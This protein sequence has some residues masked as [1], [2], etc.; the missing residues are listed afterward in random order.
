MRSSSNSVPDAWPYV[1]TRPYARADDARFV[2]RETEAAEVAA[3]WRADPITI[4]HGPRGVG[5]SSLIAAGVLPLLDSY[6]ADVLPI[7]RVS[8]RSSVPAALAG[9]GRNSFV[10][11]LLSSWAPHEAPT[12]L[13]GLTISAFLRTR[14]PRLDASG[15][16]VP[17]MAVVDQVEELFTAHDRQRRHC[18]QLIEQISAVLDGDL[19]FHLLIAVDDD[20]LDEVVRHS[21]VT[22]PP[23]RLG[24]LRREQAVAACR[25]PLEELGHTFAPGVAEGLVDD[26]ADAA[27]QVEPLLLQ[28]ACTALLSP[29]Q[30]E[31]IGDLDGPDEAIAAYCRRQLEEVAAD[32]FHADPEKLRTRLRETF[33]SPEVVT[34]T[35]GLPA[36]VLKALADRHVLARVPDASGWRIWH[37]RLRPALFRGG[38]LPG[39]A[40]HIRPDAR[41]RLAESAM[42]AGEFEVAARHGRLALREAGHDGRLSAAVESLLGDVAYLRDDLDEA[43]IHYRRATQLYVAQPG[44]DVLAATLLTATGRVLLR[45]GRTDEAIR[46]LQAAARRSP[47]DSAI[48]TELAWALWY[49]G[50]ERTAVDVLD[51]AL[52]REGNAPEAL[53]ARGEILSDLQR[54][55]GAL[56]D[57][58]RVRPLQQP[59]TRAA[60]A[61]ALALSGDVHMAVRAIPPMETVQDGSTLLRAARVM[62]AAGN[63][64]EAVRLAR[65]A[66]QS[67]TSPLLPPRLAAEAD[68]LSVTEPRTR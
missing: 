47:D 2:G 28:I 63:H 61:L 9:G 48:Q 6:S 54:P 45:Q 50:H 46:K 7:G 40:V 68:R 36:P 32:H 56:R 14:P 37:E 16:P 10:L 58:E 15:A 25:K 64:D 20:H 44:T 65:R 59:S 29:P 31:L 55:A 21:G 8:R 13:S 49:G 12:H 3:R 53:Q 42:L 24:P 43:V 19:P 23:Y 5:K 30:P 41:L 11:A 62:E 33:G 52:M 4:V 38:P 17:I 22:T 27:G 34:E 60:Y 57:L 66:R 18:E 67:T 26:L 1:G 51:D 35:A 39:G